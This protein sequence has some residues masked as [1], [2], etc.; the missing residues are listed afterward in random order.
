MNPVDWQLLDSDRDL[1]HRELK[2][3]V[4]ARVFDA[5]AHLYEAAQ[6]HPQ[7]PPLVASGPAS[8]GLDEYRKRIAELLPGRSVSGLFFGFPHP[9]LDMERANGFVSAE[10]AADPASRAL[11]LVRPDM[12]PEFIRES[13]RRFRF[14]GLKC[15][16]TYAAHQPTF[17]A[18]IPAYLPEPQM[19]IAHQERLA[20]TLHLV[21]ARALADPA[22][23]QAIRHY[24][25]RYPDAR[26]VLA[27]AARG[28]NPHH[29]IEG[30]ESLRGLRNIWCDT[31][32]VTE[33]GAIEAIAR[34]LGV[35]RLLFGSDFPVSHMRGRAVAIGDSF[36]WLSPANVDFTAAY[37]QVQLAWVGLES[38]RTLKLAAFHLHLSNAQIEDIFYR[39]AQALLGS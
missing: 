4:P 24:A 36:L 27:H 7:P 10:C 30:I 2:S 33:A 12:D 11:M 29:T 18:P 38:L 14:A 28:F 6:F 17:E 22:N 34:T 8:V 26:L 16:H 31:S 13:V 21:R 3:F 5:H 23:Q 19:E 37:A 39:N 35:D 15:Y 32:A 20:V 9:A 25:G 1:F